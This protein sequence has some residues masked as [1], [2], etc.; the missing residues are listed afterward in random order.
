VMT[1]TL[2][3][4]VCPLTPAYGAYAAGSGYP[5]ARSLAE[6]VLN[7]PLHP[8]MSLDLARDIAERTRKAVREV[9]SS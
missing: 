1:G 9:L 6:R 5:S 8:K 2:F 4:Y 7:L 3:D